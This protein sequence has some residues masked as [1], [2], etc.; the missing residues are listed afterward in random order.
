MTTTRVIARSEVSINDVR[1]KIATGGQSNGRVTQN[2][3]AGSEER[4]RVW[5]PTFKGG[6][7]GQR[8]VLH[9]GH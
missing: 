5:E 1:Y 6:I 4:P 2:L 7:G 3:I 9:R 8:V